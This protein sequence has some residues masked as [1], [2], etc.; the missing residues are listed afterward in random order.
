MQRGVVNGEALRTQL[1]AL[2]GSS[3]SRLASGQAPLRDAR[4]ATGTPPATGAAGRC[5]ARKSDGPLSAPRPR[6]GSAPCRGSAVPPAS[7]RRGPDLCRTALRVCL[8]SSIA[9]VRRLKVEL[10]ALRLLCHFAFLL[11]PAVTDAGSC[12]QGMIPS[13]VSPLPPCLACGPW[14]RGTRTAAATLPRG[15]ARLPAL[16]TQLISGLL[17]VRRPL[18]DAPARPAG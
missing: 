6:S 1:R 2:R 14:A 17:A 18:G 9:G 10:Y 7:P 13:V 12:E 5:G 3:G 16:P 11:V 4:T 15:G 8:F